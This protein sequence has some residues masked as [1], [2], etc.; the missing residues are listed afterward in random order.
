MDV[1]TSLE[2][3]MTLLQCNYIKQCMDL[4]AGLVPKDEGYC[5]EITL[6]RLYVFALMWSVGAILELDDRAK[7]EQF[8]L[9]KVS[10][11]VILSIIR[12]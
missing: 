12:T 3:K 11:L 6:K 10:T 8:L 7:M 2:P 5:A 4:L 9:D 1:M